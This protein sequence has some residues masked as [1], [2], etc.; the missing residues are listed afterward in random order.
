VSEQNNDIKLEKKQ[1]IKKGY[2]STDELVSF[3]SSIL[4][5][6]M[7]EAIGAYSIDSQVSDDL[8]EACFRFK[9]TDDKYVGLLIGKKMRN[10]LMIKTWLLSQ[11]IVIFG[12]AK[13]ISIII[14]KS[15][16]EVKTFSI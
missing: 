14:E 13:K 11:Q 2:G 3:M 15:D 10:I 8:S 4:N 7:P 9:F 5:T 6:M 12:R 1:E 16:G